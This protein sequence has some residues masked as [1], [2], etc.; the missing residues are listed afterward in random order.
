[1]AISSSSSISPSGADAVHTLIA[2][3]FEQGLL[4]HGQGELAKAMYLFEQV[5][6]L[7]PKHFDALH[8]VGIVAFQTG[9]FEM[10]AG[11]FRSALLVQPDHATPTATSATPSRKCS[12]WKMRCSVTSGRWN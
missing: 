7:A 5:L 10:A 11:F 3:L 8:L 12:T 4:F 6:K 2:P 1:M 9:D